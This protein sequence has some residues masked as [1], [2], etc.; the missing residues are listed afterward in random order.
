[1][2]VRPEFRRRGIGRYLLE[3]ALEAAGEFGYS[4][5]PLDSVRF[6]KQAHAMYRS[7]GF[8]NIEPYAESE[9]PEEYRPPVFLWK[10]R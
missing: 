9:I 8:Q 2:Y 3:A 6:M 7:I 4:A 10:W 1:M 5:I